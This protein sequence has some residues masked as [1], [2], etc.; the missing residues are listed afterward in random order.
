MRQLYFDM[1][2]ETR[3]IMINPAFDNIR[4]NIESSK[5]DYNE[6][7]DN[8]TYRFRYLLVVNI[9]YLPSVL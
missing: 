8:S 9:S 5:P 1:L 4:R 2:D 7:K 3:M 6:T